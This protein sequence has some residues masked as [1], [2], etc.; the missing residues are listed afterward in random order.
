MSGA[1]Q[2]YRWLATAADILGAEEIRRNAGAGAFARLLLGGDRPLQASLTVLFDGVA[3]QFG[4]PDDASAQRLTRLHAEGEAPDLAAS[5]PPAPPAARDCG[6]DLGRADLGLELESGRR[7]RLPRERDLRPGQWVH[8]VVAVRDAAFFVRALAQ[9]NLGLGEA[10]LAGEFEMLRG[11]V[12]HLV[13]FLLVNRIDRGIRLAGREQAKLLWQYVKWRSRRSHNEDIAEHYDVGDN[14][15][16]PMLGATGCYSCGYMRREDEDLDAIQ[17]NKMNLIFSKMQLR[18]G[19]R[20]LDTGCGNGGMLVHAALG[21]GCE[22][23][24]FT[25]SFNMASLAQRNAEANGVAA[26]VRIHHADFSLLAKYPDGHFDAVY[27]VGVWEHLPFGQYGEVMRHCHRILKPGGRMLIHSMGSHEA[28]HRRDGYIQKYIF[29]DSNQIRLH[30]LL[31]EARRHDLFVADVENIGRH[32]YW[33]LWYWRR[34]LLEAYE[35]DASI[36]RR[37]FLVMLYFLECGMAE[38]RFGDG[39]LYHLLLYKDARDYRATWRV[40]G[41]ASEAG[42]GAMR[43]VPFTMKASNGNAHLHNDAFAEGKLRAPVYRR[44]GPVQRL[45]HWY[46]ILRHVTHQ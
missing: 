17:L 8:P 26:R 28:R 30:L 3:M 31:D 37:D 27:E 5:A 7:H 1:A 10:F 22:G 4:I 29:R 25:N 6:L 18:P 41:R 9:R 32:Y 45:R 2:R 35:R 38:S 36:D 13:A 39:S 14:I 12:H 23:E 44:P 19:M 21:W 46:D 33:T 42:P 34:N 20:I 43:P 11:S 24:G 15:M 16:V 40:D